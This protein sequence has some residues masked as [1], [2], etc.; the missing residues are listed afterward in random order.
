MKRALKISLLVILG[1]AL[2]IGTGVFMFY[3]NLN[4]VNTE[5]DSATTNTAVKTSKQNNSSQDK[6]NILFVG[7]ADGLSDTIFVAS[8]DKDKKEINMLSIPRDTYYPRPGYNAPSEKKIN[9]AYSEQ[10]IDG[11]KDAVENLL[12]IKIDNYVILT[13]DGFKDII[14]TIGG[15]EVNV[16]FNM[17]YDD[18]VANPPLH[19]N[20]KKGLQVLDGEEALQFVRYRHGYTDG[21]IGRIN[22]QQEFLKSFIKKVTSPTIITK[23]PSLAITLS[24]NLKTDLTAKD[25]T[26][27]A[28]DFVKNKPQSI[29]TSILP[30]EGGYMDDYSYYFVD[31]QKAIEL[32]SKM[33]GNGLSNDSVSTVSQITYSPINNTISVAVYNGTKVQGLAAKYADELKNLGFN[34]VKIA[35]ADAK[36]YD[37]SYVCT[38]TNIDKANKVANALSIKNVLKGENSKSA[39]VTV[40]IGNDKK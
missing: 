14:D 37:E 6:K 28:L 23:I 13:Y 38:N 19:I 22:A 5:E 20:L 39:D 8:F 1:I 40:I 9:A 7:D 16:P 27:Y 2:S 25:I 24:K 15:V 36:N 4:V 29:N 31:Q 10:K 33:F 11:L 30:G 34:V 32:A 17:K 18:N 21:D 26:T 35:N 3:R 12:G